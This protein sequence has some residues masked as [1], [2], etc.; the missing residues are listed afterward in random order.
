MVFQSLVI[1]V[2]SPKDLDLVL[3]LNGWM[4]SALGEWELV[5]VVDNPTDE[6]QTRIRSTVA[7]G[8]LVNCRFLILSRRGDL[9]LDKCLWAGVELAIG[10]RVTVIYDIPQSWDSL[11]LVWGESPGRDVVYAT[12]S[13]NLG[14]RISRFRSALFDRFY[15]IFTGLPIRS[16]SLGLVD[17]SRTFAHFLQKTVRPEISLRNANL[18]PGFESTH[19]TV[20][21]DS[22][23]K[24]DSKGGFGRAAS[25]LFTA[26]FAPLRV[27]SLLALVSA[28]L[29]VI[30]AFVVLYISLT[31]VVERGWT[32]LSLQ[33]SGMFFLTS[34]VLAAITEFLIFMHGS[35]ARESSY[36]IKDEIVTE[37]TGMFK[38]LNLNEVE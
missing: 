24:R 6:T 38:S 27:V 17:M 28:F 14:R 36:F 19:V 32:S 5:V 21:N 16:Q 25:I 23:S 1:R 3:E 37:R 22:R 34:L 9:S 35:I 13:S 33:I 8:S 26:S 31:Q 12:Q 2:A 11:L 10:D 18:F 15:S 7:N 20:L 4:K 29:N 30:Y